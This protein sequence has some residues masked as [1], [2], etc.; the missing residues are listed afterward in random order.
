ML[1]IG[2]SHRSSVLILYAWAALFAGTV[3]GL[4]IVTVH[5][6][7]LVWTTLAAVLALALL[8][9]PRLRWWERS[10]QEQAPAAVRA[11]GGHTAVPSPSPG[12]GEAGNGWH[13]SGWPAVG[14]GYAPHGD[15][16]SGE[17]ADS[18]SHGRELAGQ[19][20]QHTVP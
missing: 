18:A 1:E 12:P 6:A 11:G 15:P 10:R 16:G 4:S 3:V 8:S 2:H 17:H 13:A 20:S 14:N 5:L 9:M 19:V 7:V